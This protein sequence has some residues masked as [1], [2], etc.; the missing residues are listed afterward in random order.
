MNF[1]SMF[2]APGF[3]FYG[4]LMDGIGKAGTFAPY[5]TYLADCE[6]PGM[7]M[8]SLSY[9]PAIVH[10]E[11]VVHGRLFVARQ[12]YYQ[13]VMETAD[14]IE[15]YHPDSPDVSLY[16]RELVKVRVPLGQFDGSD[17]VME[18]DAWTYVFNGSLEQ[19]HK[20]ESGRWSL[21]PADNFGEEDW[22]A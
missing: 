15:G 12:Q 1:D 7:D 3:A 22:I 20:I 18:V 5:G 9:F 21:A 19:C 2:R 17:R 14:R 6:I 8:Y 4:T 10:G 13:G 16:R 11:G